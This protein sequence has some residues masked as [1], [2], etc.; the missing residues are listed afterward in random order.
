VLMLLVVNG[1][2]EDDQ[3]GRCE[4]KEDKRINQRIQHVF[5]A[6]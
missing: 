1:K 5:S 2:S 6:H 4:R 3:L